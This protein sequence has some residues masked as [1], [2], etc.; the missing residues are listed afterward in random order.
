MLFRSWPEAAEE[1]GGG[2]LDAAIL[3]KGRDLAL[4]L[5]CLTRNHDGLGEDGSACTWRDRT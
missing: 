2:N 3:G 1:A 5:H 4:W